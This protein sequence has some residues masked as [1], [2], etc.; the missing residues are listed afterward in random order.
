MVHFV[1]GS[2]NYSI[3]AGNLA[4]VN[5]ALEGNEISVSHEGRQ[6]RCVPK[7]RA[8]E[9]TQPDYAHGDYQLR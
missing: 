4:L 5:E 8:G 6:L 7:R 2:P 1:F 3:S 9:P